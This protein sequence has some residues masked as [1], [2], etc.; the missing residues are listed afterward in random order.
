M[1]VKDKIAM[2]NSMAVNPHPAPPAKL[3]GSETHPKPK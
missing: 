2:W 1:S 3:T